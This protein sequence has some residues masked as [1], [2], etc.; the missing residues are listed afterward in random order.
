ME[1]L[2]IGVSGGIDSAFTS[3]LCA[4]TGKPVRALALPIHQSTAEVSRADTHLAWLT[5]THRQVQADT[6]DLSDSFDTF[7]QALPESAQ[8]PRALANTRSRLRMAALYA[9]AG[10]QRMLVCGTGNRVED[11]G[12]GFF[13]KYGDGGVDISPIASLL[14][15]EVY[16][17]SRHLGVSR[18][19]LEAAPT[20]GL[21]EDGR[22]DEDQIG[23]SYVEIEWAM[24]FDG[25]P[26]ELNERQTEVLEL[27]RQLNRQNAHKTQPIPVCAIPDPLRSALYS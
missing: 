24:E 20:D 17:L 6:I 9:V 18:D 4:L 7:K 15:T 12:I 8:D 21:W 14:K 25:D 3:T 22:L 11:F 26:G 23:A 5:Q 2:V 13:T 1:G 10:A 16:Q 19:I 27:Y